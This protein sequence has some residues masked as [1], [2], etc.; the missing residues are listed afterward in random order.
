MYN[1]LVQTLK[2][3]SLEAVNSTKPCDVMFGK[4]ESKN[5]IKINQKITLGKN[6]L[7]HLKDV[8]ILSGDV[9]VLLRFSGGQ[10]FL[11]LGVVDNGSTN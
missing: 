10:K 4:A 9:V 2:N 1:G 7:I 8:E 6:Q 3:I 5:S 11:V